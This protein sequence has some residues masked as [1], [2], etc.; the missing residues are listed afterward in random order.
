MI[1][2]NSRET[3][4][5]QTPDD[6]VDGGTRNELNC[7]VDGACNE[8]LWEFN[9]WH[10]SGVF[11]TRTWNIING[12]NRWNMKNFS[13]NLWRNFDLAS[14][15]IWCMLMH[16]RC[17]HNRRHHQLGRLKI[18][19]FRIGWWMCFQMVG[20]EVTWKVTALSG[21]SELWYTRRFASIVMRN[22]TWLRI[23]MRSRQ[24]I[25]S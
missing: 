15:S 12:T 1:K 14:F 13:D 18:N 3:T 25:Y 4:A 11:T 22:S 20:N 7:I 2:T 19:W 6:V 17:Q 5:E 16:L 10:V 21:A 23:K 24:R 8:N 9:C